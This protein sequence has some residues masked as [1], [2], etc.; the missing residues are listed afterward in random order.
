MTKRETG[1]NK[2]DK[3]CGTFDPVYIFLWPL[4]ENQ[5]YGSNFM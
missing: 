5:E 3:S 1:Y 4:S 2:H